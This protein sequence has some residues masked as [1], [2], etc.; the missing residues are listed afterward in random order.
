VADAAGGV[1]PPA[2]CVARGGRPATAQIAVTTRK[3]AGLADAITKVLNAQIGNGNYAAV[4]AR[5][6]V[7]SDGV[8]ESR[9]NPPGL[10]RY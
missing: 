7:I 3:D 2:D 8:T 6:G 10:Q 4:L 5:W 1:S 9:S